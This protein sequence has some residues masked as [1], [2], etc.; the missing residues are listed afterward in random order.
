MKVED[1]VL[2]FRT[3]DLT[4]NPNFS[5]KLYV[6]KKHFFKK[7][8]VL[9]DRILT[10][11]E[12]E[13]YKISDEYSIVKVNLDKLLGGFDEKKKHEIKVSL[14]VNLESGIILSKIPTLNVDSSI[15]VD[16]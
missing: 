13:S 15:T 14:N 6:E 1:H 7:D 10:S 4:K 2:T 5:L 11:T 8:E 3:G 9:I 12:F 16:N